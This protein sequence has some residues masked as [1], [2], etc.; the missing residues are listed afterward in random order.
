MLII[1]TGYCK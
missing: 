1:L